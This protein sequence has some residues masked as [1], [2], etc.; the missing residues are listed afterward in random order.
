MIT[1]DFKIAIPLILISLGIILLTAI[2]YNK[3]I[4][5]NGSGY[6][7]TGSLSWFHLAVIIIATLL[8]FVIH[9]YMN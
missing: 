1:L 2:K 7:I 5:T 4:G 3:I 6:E 9:K 8:Y